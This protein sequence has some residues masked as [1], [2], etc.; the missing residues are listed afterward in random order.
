M[1]AVQVPRLTAPGRAATAR[2]R[3]RARRAAVPAGVLR[4]LYEELG[5]TAA[6]AGQRLGMSADKVLRAAHAHGIPVRVGGAVPLPGPREIELLQA[7]YADPLI[8]AAL[9]AHDVPL[10]PPGGPVAERFPDPV[11]LTAPLVKDLYWGCGAGL[12]HIELVT[13]QPS[14]SIRG[15]MRRAGIPLRHPG[16]RSPFMRRWR[17]GLAGASARQARAVTTAT[18]ATRAISM[19]SR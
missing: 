4:L 11:P 3:A 9:T 18:T 10:V 5:M 2:A 19:Y 16:G 6:E 13:G 17:S 14:E 1:P 7:L 12:N 15:F 8:D